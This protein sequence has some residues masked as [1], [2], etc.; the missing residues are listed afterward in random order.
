MK[1]FNENGVLINEFKTRTG[2]GLKGSFDVDKRGDIYIKEVYPEG[3]YVS[4]YS[5]EGIFKRR[6]MKI[7]GRLRGRNEF[8]RFSYSK[9]RMDKR[10]NIYILFPFL[11]ELWKYDSTGKLVWKIRIKD[12]ILKKYPPGKIKWTGKAVHFSPRI[13]DMAID[14]EHERILISHIHGGIFYDTNGQKLFALT[15][16]DRLKTLFFVDI[17]DGKII[18]C[19]FGQID[20]IKI[21]R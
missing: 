9:I 3:I 16:S 6:F 10:G 8:L 11:R 20:I 1:T 13:F 18:N 21:K 7:K 15:F 17:F 14:A 4:I 5:P 2:L 19:Y 12:N